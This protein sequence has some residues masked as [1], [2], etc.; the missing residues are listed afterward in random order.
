[1]RVLFDSMGRPV[2]KR[3]IAN[4]MRLSDADGNGTVDFAEFSAIFDQIA[5]PPDSEE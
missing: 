5:C 3:I 4:I 1:M 2:S